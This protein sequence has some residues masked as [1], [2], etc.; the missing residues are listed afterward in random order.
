MLMLGDLTPILLF[1]LVGG[2]MHEGGFSFVDLLRNVGLLG[3]GWVAAALVFRPYDR[4]G[5]ARLAATWA[6]GIS[7]GVFLRAFAL[8]RVVDSEYIV[9]WCVAL[10]TT[11]VFLIA[12]RLVVRNLMARL[13]A[14]R[15]G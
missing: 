4:P 7:A 14:N 1:G 12:W 11:L 2:A 8:D 3:A 5:I 10:A 13:D 9:F 6:L 15:S